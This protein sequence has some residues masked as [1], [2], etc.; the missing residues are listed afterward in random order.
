[1]SQVQSKLLFDAPNDCE[2]KITAIAPWFGGK[3]TMA[4]DIVEELGPHASYWEP[5]CGSMAVL[6]AKPRCSQETVCDLHGDLIN[7]A[8]VLASE[9]AVELYERASRV[10]CSTQLYGE[11]LEQQ[12][13]IKPV[14]A[15]LRFLILS[16]MGRNGTSGSERSNFAPSIRFTPGGGA[17]PIRWRNA[18]ES[19]PAW[20]ERLRNVAILHHSAFDVLAKIADD[21]R[22]VIYCD[23]P[24]MKA[25]RGSGDGS[26]Y[27]HDFTEQGETVAGGCDHA[28]LA[29]LLR[30]FKQARVV[31]S[32]YDHPRVRELYAGWTIVAK[33]RQKNLHVQNRRGQGRCTAPEVLLINGPSHAKGGES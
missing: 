31:V 9:D 16:W 27:L 7:L 26:R 19:I 25:T 14:E 18:V 10:L 24:Y 8:R 28:R 3:R 6:L 4:P 20:H 11:M 22:V 2:A 15:A 5:F 29:E 32:Y 12:A 21:P 13:P 23:P 1:M 17:S 30:R 33:N